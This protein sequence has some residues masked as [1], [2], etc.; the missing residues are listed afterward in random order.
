MQSFYKYESTRGLANSDVHD[1]WRDDEVKLLNHIKVG[2][3]MEQLK[4]IAQV[5][6][7]FCSR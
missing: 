6:Q 3:R 4:K 1:Y 7:Y 5:L 2:A